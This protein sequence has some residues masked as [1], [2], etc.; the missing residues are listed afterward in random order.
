MRIEWGQPSDVEAIIRLGKQMHAES[1]FAHLAY[2]EQRLR[3][4]L[5]AAIRDERRRY[6][7]LVA[8]AADGTLAGLL[9]GNIERHYFSTAYIAQNVAFFIARPWRGSSGAVRLL[10]AFRRWAINRG[11]AELYLYQTAGVDVRR[12]HRLMRHLGF[13]HMGGSYALSLDA[14]DVG[15]PAPRVMDDRMD[16]LPSQE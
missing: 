4:V 11:A 14:R 15:A 10:T 16:R 5:E 9:F 6:C 8:R 12:F 1:R 13:E 2:D 7:V 3:A